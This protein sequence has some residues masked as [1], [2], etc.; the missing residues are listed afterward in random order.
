[1]NTNNQPNPAPARFQTPSKSYNPRLS[2]V[3]MNPGSWLTLALAGSYSPTWLPWHQAPGR[4]PQTQAPGISQHWLASIDR[5]GSCGFKFP[6]GP[7]KPR[8]YAGTCNP[9]HTSGP[10]IRPIIANSGFQPT[11]KPSQ[12]LQT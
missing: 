12:P 9:N 4:L 8:L 7:Q 6:I 1:M 2:K 10:S 5:N 3:P 11:P